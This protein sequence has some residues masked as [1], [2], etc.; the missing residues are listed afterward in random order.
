MSSETH[1]QAA[2]GAKLLPI[3]NDTFSCDT[4]KLIVRRGATLCFAIDLGR[5]NLANNNLLPLFRF[6][7]YF[8]SF[9]V[10]VPP[11]YLIYAISE[12]YQNFVNALW[13]SFIETLM[14]IECMHSQITK[15]LVKLKSIKY[16]KFY[17]TYGA[18]LLA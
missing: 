18:N 6:G 1:L 2:H 12:I 16:P 9:F 8:G 14:D 17:L 5:I 13:Y 3:S 7:N 15:N 11:Q 10:F 4:E